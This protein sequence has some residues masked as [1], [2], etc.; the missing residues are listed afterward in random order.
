MIDF[1]FIKKSANVHK[2]YTL[3]GKAAKIAGNFSGVPEELDAELK[4]CTLKDLKTHIDSGDYCALMNA[5]PKLEFDEFTFVSNKHYNTSSKDE[6]DDPRNIIPRKQEYLEKNDIIVFDF[7]EDEDC[8]E[9]IKGVSFKEKFDMLA[10]IIPELALSERLYVPSSS[11]GIY[12]KGIVKPNYGSGHV[13]VKVTD[14]KK[15]PG[16]V[17]IAKVR[18]ANQGLRWKHNASTKYLFDMSVFTSD[19]LFTISKPHLSNDLS[20]EPLAIEYIDGRALDLSEITL[21]T[22]EEEQAY[23]RR[24]KN[25]KS[26]KVKRTT[27]SNLYG[28]DTIF[29]STDGSSFTAKDFYLSGD[30]KRNCYA[31]FREDK[32][33]S[34]AMF[35]HRETGIPHVYDSALDTTYLLI[36]GC[37]LKRTWDNPSDSK[38]VVVITEAKCGTGKTT[39]LCEMIDLYSHKP[40]RHNVIILSPTLELCNDI[41]NKIKNKHSRETKIISITSENSVNVRK[42]LTRQI[43]LANIS[44]NNTGKKSIIVATHS[45]FR[46]ISGELLKDWIVVYDEVPELIHAK[47]FYFE[48]HIEE[49]LLNMINIDENNLCTLRITKEKAKAIISSKKTMY[50]DELNQLIEEILDDR[51]KVHLFKDKYGDMSFRCVRIIDEIR[52]SLKLAKSV[53]ILCANFYGSLAHHIMRHWQFEFSDESPFSPDNPTHNNTHLITIIP[54]LEK[55]VNYSRYLAEKTFIEHKELIYLLSDS[56]HN[57]LKTKYLFCLNKWMKDDYKIDL[58]DRHNQIYR[59]KYDSRGNNGY[60]DYNKI[61]FIAST[62]PSPVQM[63]NMTDLS[64]E[65]GID[66]Y[67][68]LDGWN[69]TKTYEACYQTVSR[70]CLR[71]ANN[72]TPVQI[73]VTD[74]AAAEYLLDQ[75]P[76]AI[77][78]ESHTIALPKKVD[79]RTTVKACDSRKTD[80]EVLDKIVTLT[81]LGWT[82]DEIKTELHVSSATVSKARKNAGIPLKRGR[83]RTTSTS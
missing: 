72:T 41:K 65:T 57:I 36:D 64:R 33:P 3:K 10:E 77:I 4:R 25:V 76:D 50:N 52:E 1:I 12:C 81:N 32:N 27:S 26:S 38:V 7:D 78:D 48:K 73:V 31:P 46:D 30:E 28:E 29:T 11:N 17:N 20:R 75:F 16:F 39:A 79:G 71:L 54:L 61:T 74:Y 67:T 63:K 23:Q 2:K 47:E 5:S 40:S 44:L 42:A 9:Q 60:T 22:E 55:G 45:A 62:N 83:P 56:A 59:V 19:R 13:Y 68:F 70:T 8:P 80:N 37:H 51:N 66:Y 34:A 69:K 49:D 43:T 21:L 58:E 35:K 14:A 53:H 18:L 82:R 24:S 15:I 6:S